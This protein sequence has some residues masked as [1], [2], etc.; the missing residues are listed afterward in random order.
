[1]G[2][3]TLA[4]AAVSAHGLTDV[5][6]KPLATLA[7]H[8]AAQLMPSR[9]VKPAFLLAG[10]THF[11][12]DVGLCAS[13]AMH[14]LWAISQR[15]GAGAVAW[16]SALLFSTLVHVPRH[17]A[18]VWARGCSEQAFYA[19]GAFALVLASLI[20]RGLC[21]MPPPPLAQR[22]VVAHVLFQQ[23]VL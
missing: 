19:T 7:V 23:C 5:Y 6:E 21:L 10:I 22:V 2:V 11:A 9:C 12:G 1:M 13:F 8:A 17:C 20:E 15:F 3:R 16:D 14:A 18:R 4:L